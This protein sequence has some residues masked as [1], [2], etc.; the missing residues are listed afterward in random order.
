ME[1][2]TRV[3]TQRKPRSMYLRAEKGVKLPWKLPSGTEGAGTANRGATPRR[4]T[5]RPLTKAT[6]SRESRRETPEDAKEEDMSVGVN[7]VKL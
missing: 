1:T 7:V 3:K 6:K 2:I 5:L 4:L